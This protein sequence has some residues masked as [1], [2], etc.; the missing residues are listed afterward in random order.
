MIATLEKKLNDRETEVDQFRIE[1]KEL[2]S[3]HANEKLEI[4]SKYE[5]RQEQ[6][7][8]CK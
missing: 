5:D 8:K 4:I 1:I 7:N 6:Y 2:K 3:Q